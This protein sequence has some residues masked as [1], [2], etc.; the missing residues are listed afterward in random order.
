MRLRLGLRDG[1]DAG[2]GVVSRRV[3]VVGSGCAGALARA[4]HRPRRPKGAQRSGRCLRQ[5]GSRPHDSATRRR[6]LWRSPLCPRFPR[7]RMSQRGEASRPVAV[8]KCADRPTF[9]CQ[10][11]C[12]SGETSAERAGLA[13]RRRRGSRPWWSQQSRAAALPC[14][15]GGLEAKWRSHHGQAAL[16]DMP[17]IT[18]DTYLIRAW[19]PVQF[20]GRLIGGRPCPVPGVI[21][22]V[23]LVFWAPSRALGWAQGSRGSPGFWKFTVPQ[24]GE[25]LRH[26]AEA[27]AA[28]GVLDGEVR[29]CASRHARGGGRR[30]WARVRL[31]CGGLPA[32]EAGTLEGHRNSA[33][34]APLAY[35]VARPRGALAPL[36][37]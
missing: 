13:M 22:W 36:P 26:N 23:G 4:F 5:Q 3:R 16:R 7:L 15:F 20:L 19:P 32:A 6:P 1:A 21:C 2:I 27:E 14:I 10:A 12:V 30:V 17:P 31:V 37:R 8:P 34:C 9:G 25:F 11:P 24:Y 35:N 29:V 18:I 33:R 28:R